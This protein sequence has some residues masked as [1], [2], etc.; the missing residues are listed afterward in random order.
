MNELFIIHLLTVVRALGC[1]AE[2]SRNYQS[3]EIV[4]RARTGSGATLV[5]LLETLESDRPL[6]N[7][8][9]KVVRLQIKFQTIEAGLALNF[10]R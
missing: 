2:G 9:S 3:S 8:V 10:E 7:V 6:T 5:S 4:I 1:T